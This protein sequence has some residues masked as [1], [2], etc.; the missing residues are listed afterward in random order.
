M[1]CTL[2]DLLA[3]VQEADLVQLTDDDGQGV[4]D[5][6]KA[7]AAIAAAEDLVDGYLRGRYTLPLDPIPKL[8]TRIAVDI[9]LFNLYKRRLSLKM[10]ESLEKSFDNSMKVLGQ[11]QSGKVSLG[12]DTG[13][14]TG[15]G[16]FK[17]NK[18]SEDRAF[19]RDVMDKF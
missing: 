15:P 12:V 7:A 8:V 13:T 18:R 2:F 5:E 3:V 16:E 11:I 1:Y 9:S 10:P 14:S 17:T 19:T 4:I 6:E